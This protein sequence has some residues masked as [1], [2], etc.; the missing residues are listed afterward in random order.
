[1][2]TK[3]YVLLIGI[4]ISLILSYQAALTFLVVAGK[5]INIDILWRMFTIFSVS[6][7]L[8]GL[9]FWLIKMFFLDDIF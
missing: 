6:W 2:E 7:I 1:M 5:E 9:F 8:G 4:V 3:H